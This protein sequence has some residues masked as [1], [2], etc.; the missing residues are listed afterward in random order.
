MTRMSRNEPPKHIQCAIS[1]LAILGSIG[2][3][4]GF[5]ALLSWLFSSG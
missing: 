4:A 5:C 2:L 1:A 3:A